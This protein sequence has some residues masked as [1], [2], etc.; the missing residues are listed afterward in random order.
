MEKGVALSDEIRAY[1]MELPI[2]SD[3]DPLAYWK[4]K[5]FFYPRIAQ[6]ARRYLAIP[7]TSVPCER[8][9]STA[10][11]IVTQKRNRLSSDTAARLVFLHQNRE[12][13]SVTEK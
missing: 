9:F 13:L 5:R 2:E 1:Q 10:G 6:L 8:L 4:T 12:W 7:A 11:N 3:G